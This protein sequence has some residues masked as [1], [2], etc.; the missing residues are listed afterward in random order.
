MNFPRNYLNIENIDRKKAVFT[1]KSKYLLSDQ[2]DC[3]P[4]DLFIIKNEQGK[5]L[6]NTIMKHLME[7]GASK[8]KGI[9]YIKDNAEF[10][11]YV[12]AMDVVSCGIRWGYWERNAGSLEDLSNEILIDELQDDFINFENDIK[13][14]SKAE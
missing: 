7:S 10:P 5:L 8:E 4:P 9:D 12:L 13:N 6:F 11:Y 1:K 14:L 3:L 2:P